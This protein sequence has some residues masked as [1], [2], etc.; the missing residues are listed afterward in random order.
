MP[1]SST[2]DR[3][4]AAEWR[5]LLEE[6]Q[7]SG[8]S[9]DVFARE[10]GLVPSTFRWWATELGRRD[11]GR[12]ARPDDRRPSPKAAV[13]L[14]VRVIQSGDEVS[15]TRSAPSSSEGTTVELQLPDVGLVRVPVG[16]DVAWVARL[17]GALRGAARC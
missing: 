10:R 2:K 12:S 5:V 4:S 17:A 3:R 1:R 14:P 8:E 7:R 9:K 15:S 6:W 16:A 11:A 13:F